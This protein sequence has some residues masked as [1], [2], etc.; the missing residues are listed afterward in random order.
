MDQIKK[1]QAGELFRKYG[2]LIVLIIMLLI[3]AVITPNFVHI[4]T[5]W[6]VLIQAFCVLV[7]SMGMTFVI[8]TGGI[9]ISVGSTMAISSIIFAKLLIE[10]ECSFFVSILA[11][12]LAACIF[13]AFN[14]VLIGV[15]NFQ[16]IVATLILMISGRGIAQQF[17]NGAVISFYGN[18]YSDIGTYRIG[19]L[20]P[21]Q[22]I[23]VILIIAIAL[24]LA[25]NTTFGLYV[26][27]IGDNS[28]ASKLV[29]IRTTAIIVMTYILCAFL[30]G[31][32]ASLETLRICS[33]DP[34]NI[35]NNMELDCIAAVAI[36]GTPMSG[37]KTIIWGTVV[38][39]LVMQLIT[40]MMNMNNIFYAYALVIKSAII[41]IAL[42]LQKEKT[43]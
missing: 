25:K 43:Q 36:G 4:N 35:G 1:L 13:G 41:I 15:F 31:F 38:G 14:G 18:K 7:I 11:A 2:A 26:Q 20:V 5:M 17:N 28:T 19:G 42:Y 16:P 30:A 8:A 23:I 27:S 10:M 39:A 9:D 21:I 37:G 32:A 33:A 6:N 22:V 29:G 3:N 40:T 24:F 34:N 12:L